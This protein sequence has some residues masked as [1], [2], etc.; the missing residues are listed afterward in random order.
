VQSELG[1]PNERQDANG[2]GKT[3]VFGVLTKH[4]EMQ[5]KEVGMGCV[6]QCL[7]VPCMIGARVRE[8]PTMI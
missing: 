4:G 5:F 6:E 1:E 7:A 3:R 8:G 2:L